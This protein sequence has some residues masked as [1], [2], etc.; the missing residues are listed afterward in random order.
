VS[1]KVVLVIE[2]AIG[3]TASSDDPATVAE[4]FTKIE[5]SM[6]TDAPPVVLMAPPACPP[7]QNSVELHK[8][9]SSVP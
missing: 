9:V 1:L 8:A 7:T 3:A 6:K 4:L 5:L 2:N